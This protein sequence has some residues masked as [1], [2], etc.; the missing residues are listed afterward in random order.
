MQVRLTPLSLRALRLELFMKPS[1]NKDE[2]F[3]QRSTWHFASSHGGGKWPNAQN[4]QT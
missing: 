1:R 2:G 3:F 4:E